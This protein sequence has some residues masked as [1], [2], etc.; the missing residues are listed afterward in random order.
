MLSQLHKGIIPFMSFH[1]G[2]YSNPFV[3]LFITCMLFQL[4][5][6]ITQ[7][8]YDGKAVIISWVTAD[9]PGPSKVQYGTSE[10]NYEFT[11]DGKM[12]NYTFYKYNSGYIHHVFV[13]GLEVIIIIGEVILSL[14]A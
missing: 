14:M 6:H 8:D 12:T 9:E 5:V 13:D 10:K 1:A 7:G 3:H 2:F 11:A 4:K